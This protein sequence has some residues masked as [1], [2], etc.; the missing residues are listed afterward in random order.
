MDVRPRGLSA[1]AKMEAMDVPLMPVPLFAS[2]DVNIVLGDRVDL[3]LSLAPSRPGSVVYVG[4]PDE[5]ATAL[6][7][8]LSGPDHEA[9]VLQYQAVALVTI[10]ELAQQPDESRLARVGELEAGPAGDLHSVDRRDLDDLLVRAGGR[11]PA[12]AAGWRR[13]TLPDI[14]VLADRPVGAVVDDLIRRLPMLLSVRLALLTRPEEE[15]LRVL[16][17]QPCD[18]RRHAAGTRDRPASRPGTGRPPVE[19]DSGGGR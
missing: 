6:L 13:P 1:S 12:V 16:V 15:R 18:C 8:R 10:V 7:L 2:E 17:D 5:G 14:A 3:P 19:G 4:S 9:D 11:D